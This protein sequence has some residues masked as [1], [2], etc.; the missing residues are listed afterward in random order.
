[1]IF[2]AIQAARSLHGKWLILVLAFL[3]MLADSAIAQEVRNPK[4]IGVIWSG[5][6]EATAPYWGAVI[7]GLREL[8]WI[9]GK[10]AHFIM[11][12]DDDD[13]SRLPKLAA[14][15]V[16]LG[17]DAFAVTSIAAPAA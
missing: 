12:F 7:D 3:A 17:V 1:M 5:T 6:K 2:P 4:K 9:E 8:G 15:L 16:G 13:K 10:T 11:R 14:E